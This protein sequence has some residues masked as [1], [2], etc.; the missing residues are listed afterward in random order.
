MGSEIVLHDQFP[1]AGDISGAGN[2]KSALKLGPKKNSLSVTSNKDRHTK[3]NGRGRRVRM[4]ALCAA[5]VFQLTKELGHKTDGETIEWLL[6]NAEPAII[7]ATGTGTVPASHFTTT[8]TSIPSQPSVLAP[9]SRA[10]PVSGF[11]VGGGIFAMTSQPQPS[12]RLD[13]CQPSMEFAGNSYRHM[14]FTALLLQPVTADD[15]GE[16]KVAG[17]DGKQ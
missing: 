5:R 9:L 1:S 15:G 16:E 8:A 17:E 4:P 2:D 11:P 10:M 3:V 7:A 6:R 14:P 12:C 13:L